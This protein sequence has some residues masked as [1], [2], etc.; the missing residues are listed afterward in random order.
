MHGAQFTYFKNDSFDELARK[1]IIITKRT[2]D[3]NPINNAT[4]TTVKEEYSFEDEVQIN[5]IN[6]EKIK[7]TNGSYCTV[8]P[9]V[10]LIK[11]SS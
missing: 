9:C 7:N 4:L 5:F 11:L 8:G 1:E 3:A 2:I 6:A 10:T